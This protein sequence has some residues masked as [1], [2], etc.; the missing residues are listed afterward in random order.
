MQ[1][2]PKNRVMKTQFL[3]KST[4]HSCFAAMLAVLAG[5]MALASGPAAAQAIVVN[6][7]ACPTAAVRFTSA[8]MVAVLPAS[9]SGNGNACASALIT[10][11][12]TGISIQA[13]ASCATT[14]D[15]TP[16]ALQSATVNG[17][18]CDGATV[19]LTATGVSINAPTACL[20]LPP[21][22]PPPPPTS[23][24]VI[25]NIGPA[26][27]YPGQPV[28][29]TG[30]NFAAGATVTVGGVAAV[31]LGSSTATSVT[32]SIPDATTGA[33]PVIVTAAGQPSAAFSMNISSVPVGQMALLAVQSRKVHGAAGG[34]FNV[35][36]DTTQA[37]GGLL[38]VE[39]RSAGAGHVIVFQFQGAV[40]SPGT[41][42]A[43][44]STGA[45][46][47][48][49]VQLSNNEISVTLAN[50]PDARRVTVSLVGA[51]G[52]NGT[53]NVAAS[54]GFLFGDVNNSRAVNSSDISA[55]KARSGET[56]TTANFRND[57]NT[58]G[59]INSSDISAVKARSGTAL[60]P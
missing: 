29:V 41:V 35:P 15:A 9:C 3:K 1:C 38:T 53:A 58:S 4:I 8:G 6:G 23:A 52:I 44:D 5:F 14:P 50:V 45:T 56:T 20:T 33:Q 32:V 18:P 46:L 48:A 60:Q 31:V 21:P 37:I 24:P 30:I 57:V 11:S 51:S 47:G 36:V 55:M 12:S 10:Y 17:N 19:I 7:V 16:I 39:P 34:T 49:S 43:V 13:P 25:S 27:A 2:T 40:T 42:S 22:P 54:I 59:A 26:T 28:T